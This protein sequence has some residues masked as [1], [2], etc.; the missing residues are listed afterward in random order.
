MGVNKFMELINEDDY[1]NASFTPIASTRA[2]NSAFQPSGSRPV[3]CIYV[4]RITTPQ[5]AGNNEG[6]VDFL[7]DSA[8]P[9]TTVR[10]SVAIG[11]NTAGGGGVGGSAAVSTIEHNGVL[12]YLCPKRHY[13]QLNSI[14]VA[15]TPVFS[16]ANQIELVL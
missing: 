9:P 2:L 15:G 13:I 12:V 10:E 14:T 16:I 5:A 6:R 3:L 1:I 11:V 4:I 7:S 8:N